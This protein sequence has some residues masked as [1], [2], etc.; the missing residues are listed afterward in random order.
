MIEKKYEYSGWLRI[1]HWIRALSIVVLTVTGFYIAVPFI[2]PHIT[3]EPVNF[4][5][6]LFRSWHEIFG[7]LLICVTIGKIYLFIFDKQSKGER[8]SF[9]DFISP[10]VWIAQ[11][12][13]YMLVG[14]HP[15]GRGVY[16]PLQFIAYL[17]V[18]LALI[19]VSIT[20]LVLYVHNF[21]EGLGGALYDMVKPF[22]I[23]MGGLAGTRQIH[24]ISMW[25]FILFLPVHIYMAVFNSVFGKHGTL[26][27]IFSGYLWTHKKDD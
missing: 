21:H 8:R 25:V 16:N 17:T 27:S 20:G 24:H 26:D 5:N 14:K 11:I 6:A 12:K 23:M 7:F 2:A 1:T 13:Y 22:E 3:N 10:K 4:M 18:Y 15:D 19:V 9:I